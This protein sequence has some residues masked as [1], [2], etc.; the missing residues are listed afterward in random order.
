MTVAFFPPLSS[1]L[2]CLNLCF[3]CYTPEDWVKIAI[4]F[5]LHIGATDNGKALAIPTG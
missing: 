1:S 3:D 2:L 4:P 5:I